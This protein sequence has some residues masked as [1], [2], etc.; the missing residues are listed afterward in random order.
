MIRFFRQS[1]NA[2]LSLTKTSKRG[3]KESS[4]FTLK[5]V[6]ELPTELCTARSISLPV[7][8]SCPG[9]I[10][11]QP[12]CFSSQKVTA[13]NNGSSWSPKGGRSFEEAS[14]CVTELTSS[15][16]RLPN[17][18]GSCVSSA[19]CRPLHPLNRHSGH[20]QRAYYLLPPH[21]HHRTRARVWSQ[22]KDLCRES[23][24]VSF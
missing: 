20:S 6:C 15:E 23:S 24:F 16:G 18:P 9:L 4:S 5:K 8:P 7:L 1:T 3:T 21:V 22:P 12:H 2:V 19:L 14:A 13:S 10:L 17:L 11:D